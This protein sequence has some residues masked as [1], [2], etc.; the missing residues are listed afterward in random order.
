[1]GLRRTPLRWLSSPL[2]FYGVSQASAA[3]DFTPSANL[4]CFSSSV[5]ENNLNDTVITTLLK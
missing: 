5:V 4:P 3:A 2:R 1:M